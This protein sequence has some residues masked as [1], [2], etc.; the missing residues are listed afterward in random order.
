MV[1]KKKMIRR[2]NLTIG[3]FLLVTL[4][5][6]GCGSPPSK[7]VTL[8]AGAGL[9][10]AVELLRSA[11][12][13]KTGV[14][15]EV[16]YAG[17]GVVLARVQR[18]PQAD[19]F[20]PADVWYINKLQA[21]TGLVQESA[22]VTRLIPVLIVF[23]KNPKQIVT[24]ADL[25]RPEVKTALGNPKACQIG[26]LSK[27]M[28]DRAGLEWDQ[29]SDEE[30]LT[31]NELAIWVKMKAVDAA[32]VWGST[33]VTVADHVDVITLD[34]MPDEVSR[35]DCALMTTAPN[36]ATA[37]EFMDFMTGPEGQALFE[38]AGFSGMSE[39]P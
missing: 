13:Q 5:M 15:V 9:R 4:F 10:D 36:A 32:L 38:Q 16:D 23:K 11:F 17:S 34:A 14:T 8:Y 22:P 1:M 7:T 20:M 37:R 39:S 31:V 26:R 27:Q 12:T 21:E 3:F 30:S 33:A 29:V 19:L 24:L 2:F 6:T 18:D 25:T 28:M 35:V